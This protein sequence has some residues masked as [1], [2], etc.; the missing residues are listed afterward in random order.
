MSVLTFHPCPIRLL[1]D[2]RKDLFDLD[3]A[4]RD[5]PG[6]IF[7]LKCVIKPDRAGILPVLRENEN[8]KLRS[9]HLITPR[10]YD[11]ILPVA[12]KQELSLLPVTNRSSLQ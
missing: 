12:E 8:L 6:K 7:V 5:R 9:L 2:L 11:F 10:R 4:F 1:A 3:A